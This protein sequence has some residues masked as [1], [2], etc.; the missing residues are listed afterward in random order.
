MVLSNR[1][2]NLHWNQSDTYWICIIPLTENAE[3]R[4]PSLLGPLGYYPLTGLPKASAVR[5]SRRW[6]GAW[7]TVHEALFSAGIA[8]DVQAAVVAGVDAPHPSQVEIEKRSIVAMSAIAQSL[9]LGEALLEDRVLCYLQPV[10]DGRSNV[11]GYESFVR[12]R[13]GESKI[14]S[15]D[16]IVEAS[17][18]LGIE[19]IIDRH[20]HVEAIKTFAS[21]GG[22]GTLFVNFF[23]G[24]IHRPA[25]Y[26]EGLSDAVKAYG[27]IPKNIVLDVTQ[28]E[29]PRDLEHMRGVVDYCRGRGYAIALDDISSSD[30]VARLV[31]QVRPDFVKIDKSL[32]QQVGL[33]PAREAILQIASST[34]GH[35]G[36]VV[37]E[38]VELEQHVA[39]LRKTGIDLFQGY[40]FSPP[41]PAAKVI[42]KYGRGAA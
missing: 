32:V 26:L 11:F 20:L 37:A 10:I 6:G 33:P 2:F 30:T 5:A 13:E 28:S 17:K 9:W 23:P 1:I 12:V 19:F 36:V 22:S 31:P 24:F 39:E 15:G 35:G 4:L 8:T 27:L 42:E 3:A 40:Y 16:R 14:I 21:C 18:A 25:V 29:I 38:G 34:H 41:I 7:T